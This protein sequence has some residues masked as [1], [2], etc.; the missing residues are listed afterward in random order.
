VTVRVQSVRAE[1]VRP[2]RAAVLRPG[3]P[4]E[5]SVYPQDDL[6][7]TLHL[8]A[9]DPEGRVVGCATFFP[10]PLDGVPAWRLR[11]MAADPGVRGTGVG[12]RLLDAGLTAAVAA[13]VPLVWC[14]ARTSAIGF[15][16]RAGFAVVSDEFPAVSGIPHV[17]MRLALPPVDGGGPPAAGP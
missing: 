14:N 1:V 6:P 16:R 2:L 7:S 17:V 13:G 12:V 5:Q 4:L 9:L 15:Y 8:A 11:G 3:L 10:E